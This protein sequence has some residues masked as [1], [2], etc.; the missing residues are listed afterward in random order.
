MATI[1]DVARRAGVSAGTVS[2]VLNRPGYVSAE[3]RERV[4]DAIAELGFAPDQRARQFRVGRQRILGLAV[5]DLA[6]PFF[7]DVALGAADYARGLGAGVILVHDDNDGIAE[8]QNLDILIQQRV[9][10]IIVAPVDEA[11]PRLEALLNR[12]VPLVYV[13]RISGD[14]PVCFVTV[15]NVA[16]GRKAA[17]HLLEQGRRHLVVAGGD[18]RRPQVSERRSGFESL[19]RTGATVTPMDSPDWTVDDGRRLA[20]QIVALP[21][22]ERPDGIFAANDLVA[23]G[24]LHGLVASGIQV[25]REMSIVGFDD[26]VWARDAIVPLTTVRQ[27]RTAIGRTAVQMLLD[28]ID[29]GQQH[30]H[31]RSVLDP[32]LVVRDSSVPR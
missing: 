16:G 17:Q 7:V 11:N 2:N 19:A 25:P 23:L 29:N 3:T 26:I 9:H 27:D 32:E 24:L 28:E 20:E 21:G 10:G 31:T 12:G 4:Q 15:D 22:H 30:E 5:A 6:N 8:Q 13:D 1:R 14:R 18:P